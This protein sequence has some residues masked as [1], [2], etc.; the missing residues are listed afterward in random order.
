MPIRQSPRYVSP[1]PFFAQVFI[2]KTLSPRFC[3]CSFCEAWQDSRGFALFCSQLLCPKHR[4]EAGQGNSEPAE[5]R[6]VGEET[7]NGLRRMAEAERKSI[8]RTCAMLS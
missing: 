4:P 7:A 8:Q 6:K 5:V 2:R 3:K 1:S